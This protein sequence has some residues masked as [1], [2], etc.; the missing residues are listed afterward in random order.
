MIALAAGILLAVFLFSPTNT[1][2]SGWGFEKDGLLTAKLSAPKY[3]KSLSD[4]AGDWTTKRPDSKRSL[5]ARLR[6]YSRGCAK[7]IEAP[8]AQLTNVDRKW[9]VETCTKWKGDIDRLIKD[10][11]SDVK[12]F[13]TGLEEGDA[14]AERMKVV[15]RDK[16]IELA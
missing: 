10:L 8:N 4:A 15:L 16:A 6:E 2:N 13:S 5:V 12:S 1:I 11:E 14:L 9:L 3:L 7:L